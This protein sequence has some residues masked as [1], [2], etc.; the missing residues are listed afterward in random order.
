MAEEPQ[1]ILKMS[2]QQTLGAPNRYPH[3][4]RHHI[5]ADHIVL[6]SGA[7]GTQCESKVELFTWRGAR[8][9]SPGVW[10]NDRWGPQWCS[11]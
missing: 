2:T 3:E 7:E 8:W 6:R 5:E 9:A 11:Q 10:K 4:Q 1:N